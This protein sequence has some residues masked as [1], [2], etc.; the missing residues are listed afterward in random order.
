MNEFIS[1]F[2][3][4][5]AFLVIVPLCYMLF[6]KQLI[7]KLRYLVAYLLVA[8]FTELVT[9][10]ATR[11]YNYTI[12]NS[13]AYFT[14]FEVGMVSMML[15]QWNTQRKFRYGLIVLVYS[16][17]WLVCM[18][19]TNGPWYNLLFGL[20]RVGL[21]VACMYFLSESIKH[22][23]PNWM[24]TIALAFLSNQAFT[25][26]IFAYMQFF[27]EHAT[28]TF[29]N[30]YFFIN[31]IANAVLYTLVTIGILQCRKQSF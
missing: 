15:A 5:C 6:Y 7:G 11:F 30:V 25:A 2:N 27:I 26:T 8:F 24:R 14:L 16:L 31:A 9:Y 17:L 3:S 10:T 28:T 23:Y 19:A 1:Y 13:G 22:T 18:L 21:L 29:I 12:P 20:S 4:V